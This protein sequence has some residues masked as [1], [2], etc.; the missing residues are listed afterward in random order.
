M[1]YSALGDK[2]S[3]FSCGTN[4]RFMLCEECRVDTQ[5][6]S[7]CRGCKTSKELTFDNARSLLDSFDHFGVMLKNGM[8]FVFPKVCPDCIIS[9]DGCHFILVG[10]KESLI[11]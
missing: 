10:P 3:C 1:G 5:I 8:T 11:H 9:E 2:D 7:F 4:D 6:R